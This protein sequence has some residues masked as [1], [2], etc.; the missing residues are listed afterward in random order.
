LSSDLIPGSP[1]LT[2]I[3][4]LAASADCP[5]RSLDLKQ[6]LLPVPATTK[7]AKIPVATDHPMTRDYY[8]QGILG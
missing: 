7:S 5:V 6:A 3:N 2:G 1:L 8:W 4:N